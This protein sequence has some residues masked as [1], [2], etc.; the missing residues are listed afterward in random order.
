MTIAALIQTLGMTY[1]Q[2]QKGTNTTFNPEI[3]KVYSYIKDQIP[4]EEIIIFRK[5][6]VIRF[7]TGRNAIMVHDYQGAN[8]D[9]ANYCLIEPRDEIPDG[10]I[11]EKEW[12]VMRLLKRE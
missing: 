12:E 10:F 1:M 11:L 7:F 9:L 2:R 4:E 3:Q 5:P 8:A 6:R